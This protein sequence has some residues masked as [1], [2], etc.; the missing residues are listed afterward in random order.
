MRERRENSMNL[1]GVVLL[2]TALTLGIGRA[3]ANPT[4]SLPTLDAKPGDTV[5]VE[6]SANSEVQGLTQLEVYL[7][8]GE[9]SPSSA[10]KLVVGSEEEIETPFVGT[11]GFRDIVSELN[12]TRA[13]MSNSKGFNG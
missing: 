10:P 8:Y 2:C 9:K 4:L 11:G 12:Q 7:V 5:R 6:V 13:K 1:K 3:Q